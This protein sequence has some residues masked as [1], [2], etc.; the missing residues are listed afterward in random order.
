LASQGKGHTKR[1]EQNRGERSWRSK[2]AFAG[3]AGE[4]ATEALF[5]GRRGRADGKAL[6]KGL[7][8]RFRKTII[9]GSAEKARESAAKCYV[10]EKK[11][12]DGGG[13]GGRRVKLLGIKNIQAS[14]KIWRRKW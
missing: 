11:S 9:E 8:T 14:A 13:S 10:C 12:G 6:E 4:G 3:N 2:P 7:V 1:L 5:E